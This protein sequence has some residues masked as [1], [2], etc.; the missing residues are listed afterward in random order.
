MPHAGV[1]VGSVSQAN[2]LIIAGGGGSSFIR[3]ERVIISN[4]TGG[5]TTPA[6]RLIIQH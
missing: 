6:G 3:N 2:S 4:F 1:F 5:S